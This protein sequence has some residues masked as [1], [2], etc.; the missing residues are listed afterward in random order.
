V[1]AVAAGRYLGEIMEGSILAVALFIG[2]IC[3]GIAAAI[4]SSK[5]GSGVGAFFVG[6]LLGPIGV[7]IAC[8]MGDPQRLAETQ[9]TQGNRKKCPRCAELVMA[10]ARVC[11][12]C[13][14][15]F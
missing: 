8:F 12:F 13:N 1:L 9:M 6:L 7:L 15:E 10:E 4:A 2:V 14:H 3:G 11:R 5:G